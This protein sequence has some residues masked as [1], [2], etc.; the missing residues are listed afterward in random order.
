MKP[1]IPENEI[2]RLTTLQLYQI[3][4]TESE[5]AFDELTQIAALICDTPISLI[6]IIDENRQ[7]FKS[8]VGLTATETSRDV[9]FCAHAILKNEL[10]II[11]DAT[12]DERFQDNPFVTQDPNVRFYA[13][14]PLFVKEDVALGTLC[15]VD[16][17]PRKLDKKQTEALRVLAQAA[18]TQ[19]EVRRLLKDISAIRTLIPI[20]SWCH[21][22][23]NTDSSWTPLQEYM[24]DDI[25]ITHGM[26]PKC[27]KNMTS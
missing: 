9:A 15:V 13:G 8:S 27:A 7:W 20:C 19:L 18:V 5:K 26:C 12:K 25:Q 17:K 6:T 22:V 24:T 10:M 11:E 14:A 2:D 23:R 3:L 1:P 4:D 16:T 21:S